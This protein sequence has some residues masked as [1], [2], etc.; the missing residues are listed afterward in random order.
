MSTSELSYVPFPLPPSG[1][2]D[3]GAD[4]SIY[5]PSVYYAYPPQSEEQQQE[6]DEENNQDFWDTNMPQ[7]GHAYQYHPHQES[8][9]AVE[10]QPTNDMAGRS[11][12]DLGFD[13]Y[14]QDHPSPLVHS[15]GRQRRNPSRRHGR[16]AWAP[17]ID[18]QPPSQLGRDLERQPEV[19]GGLN[20]GLSDEERRVLDE[21]DAAVRMARLSGGTSARP[22]WGLGFRYGL[23]GE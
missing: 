1:G 8:Q 17:H 14:D 23:G 2:D 22:G 6:G 10:G 16:Q 9:T 4:D 21:F 7:S 18:S 3:A 13:A 20:M 12:T 5:L 11:Q 15:A 19:V